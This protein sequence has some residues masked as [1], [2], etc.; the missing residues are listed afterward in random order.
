[1][2]FKDL[3][4]GMFVYIDP[5]CPATER[6]YGFIESMFKLMGTVQKIDHITEDYIEIDGCTWDPKDVSVP[7][8]KTKPAKPIKPVIFDPNELI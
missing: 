3:R 5:R 8:E 6:H 2:E 7:V 4:K 1:M